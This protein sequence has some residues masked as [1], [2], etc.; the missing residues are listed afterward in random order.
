M[1]TTAPSDTN[2]AHRGRRITWEEFYRLTDR[3]PPTA[4]NDN[5]KTEDRG[6]ARERRNAS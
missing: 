5:Q 1:T 3:K 6:E 2:R 4:G